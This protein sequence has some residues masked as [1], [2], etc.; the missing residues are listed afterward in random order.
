MFNCSGLVAG[1]LH[2]SN[3]KLAWIKE[4]N[5][6]IPDN[7]LYYKSH[8]KKIFF[9]IAANSQTVSCH[10]FKNNVKYKRNH[11]S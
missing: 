8:G 3:T 4:T 5:G 1:Q 7:A 6:N 11:V 2:V 9:C 10:V